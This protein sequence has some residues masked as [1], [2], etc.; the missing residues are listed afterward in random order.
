MRHRTGSSYCRKAKHNVPVSTVGLVLLALLI[1]VPQ[2]FAQS[3][4]VL[5]HRVERALRANDN[6]NGAMCYSPAPGVIVLHGKVF[7]SQDRELAETTASNVSGVQQVV[8]TLRTMTGQWMAE[9]E[10]IND[11][12]ALNGLDGV[13]ARVIGSQLYLSG[14]V[15][16]QAEKQRAVRV[17][18]SISNLQLNNFIW[19][20]PGPI[21][22]GL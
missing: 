3:S 14:T 4:T 2:A 16:G 6:L 15:I 18:S 10:R 9:E 13:S 20:K 8:N 19:V 1:N 17:V 7:D 22:Q 11:T 12:L 21:F 5:M